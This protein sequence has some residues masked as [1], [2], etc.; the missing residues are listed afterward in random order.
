[1]AD[2]KTLEELAHPE[3]W[4]NRYQKGADGGTF[5]WFK[6]F[7]NLEGFFTQYLPK[8]SNEGRSPQILHLGCGNSE[9]PIDLH[10]IGYRNQVCVD[11]SEVVINDMGTRNAERD[12]IDWKV[13][14]V[15]DL[16]DINDASMD[17]AID[18]GTLDAMLSG[19]LW[20]PP[21]PVRKNTTAYIDQVVRVLKPGGVFIYITYRQPHFMKPMV[22][23]DGKW[24]LKV[25]TLNEDAGTFDYFAFVMTKH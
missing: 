23:R 24:D 1:M 9:L 22:A 18:K 15:R 12:G 20:D 4:N 13:A 10:S 3:Y 5:E 2:A 8:P 7:K 25:I 21:E 17:V 14:D 16:K 19:S 11:F 6:S